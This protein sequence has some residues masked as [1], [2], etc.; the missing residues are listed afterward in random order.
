MHTQEWFCI[1]CGRTSD[2]ASEKDAR[3][4]MKLFECR[5]PAREAKMGRDYALSLI[6]PEFSWPNYTGDEFWVEESV[7]EGVAQ[8]ERKERDN[9][10][11]LR[12]KYKLDNN[13]PFN[14]DREQIERAISKLIGNA[15]DSAAPQ[16][17]SR[18]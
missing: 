10:K 14:V 1:V 4:E 7:R 2:Q 6:G 11:H 16:G 15:E 8:E 18:L 17:D 12:E 13:P 9:L 5:L 3:I